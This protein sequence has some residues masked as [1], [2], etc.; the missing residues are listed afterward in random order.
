[1]SPVPRVVSDAGTSPGAAGVLDDELLARAIET[2]GPISQVRML[3]E[4]CSE[5]AAAINRY[6]DRGRDGALDALIQEVA[7][8]VITARQ[9]ALI[10]GET[11]VNVAIVAKLDRL[12]ARLD[13]ESEG[14][15]EA[16]VRS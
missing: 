13:A 15:R 1:M 5:C 14:A 11:Q 6:L 3:Q 16:E 12:R 7:D 10:V 2:W 9:V 4:E 8:V